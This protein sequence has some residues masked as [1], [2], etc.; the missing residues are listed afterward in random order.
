MEGYGPEPYD[1]RI[2][3]VY[4]ELFH[5]A[6]STEDTVEFLAGLAGSGPCSSSPSAPGGCAP[7]GTPGE[8]VFLDTIFVGRLKG[9]GKIWQYSAVDGARSFGFAT[10]R[11]AQAQLDPVGRVPLSERAHPGHRR[12]V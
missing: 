7:A 8:Q 10:P 2:A 12:R 1:D 6:T 9:V 5:P 4:D 11:S 3:E